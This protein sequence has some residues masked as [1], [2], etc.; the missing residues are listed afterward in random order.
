MDLKHSVYNYHERII[1][2]VTMIYVE[3]NNNYLL[4]CYSIV[5]DGVV[6]RNYRNLPNSDGQK[7]NNAITIIFLFNYKL[8]V[9]HATFRGRNIQRRPRDTTMLWSI[10]LIVI[11]VAMLS[12]TRVSGFVGCQIIADD[13]CK[14][15]HFPWDLSIYQL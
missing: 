5:T 12:T 4:L 11:A 3:I 13:E 1:I 6:S 10:V 8:T 15:I 9:H 7:A 2:L 14:F